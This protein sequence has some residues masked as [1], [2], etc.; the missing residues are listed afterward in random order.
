MEEYHFCEGHPQSAVAVIEDANGSETFEVLDEGYACPE[1]A[2]GKYEIEVHSGGT[3]SF[4]FCEDY[5]EENEDHIVNV[6]RTL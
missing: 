1:E 3:M 2:I 5:K 4:W 6:V